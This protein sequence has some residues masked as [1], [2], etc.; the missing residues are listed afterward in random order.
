M[1]FVHRRKF[2]C[3]DMM[4]LCHFSSR[5]ERGVYLRSLGTAQ[6]ATGLCADGRVWPDC[7]LLGNKATSDLRPPPTVFIE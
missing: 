3:M 1:M 6:Q 2:S 7:A 5:P 4:L